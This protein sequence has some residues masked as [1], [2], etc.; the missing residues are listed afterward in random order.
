MEWKK[1]K[2][3]PIP[4]NT[5]ILAAHVFKGEFLWIASVFVEGT[6]LLIIELTDEYFAPVG[7]QEF[8]YWAE[9]PKTLKH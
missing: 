1:V 7:F 4:V 9:M 8:N 3:H 2:E 6:G 5:S